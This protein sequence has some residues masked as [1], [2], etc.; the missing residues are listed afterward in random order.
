MRGASMGE[1]SVGGAISE[2]FSLIRR[3]PVTVLVWGAVQAGLAVLVFAVLS[4]VYIAV[5]EAVRAG[6][7]GGAGAQA[8]AT[9]PALAQVQ[10]L[11]YLL[12]LVELG[13][14]VVLYCAAFRAVL[15][16]ERGQFA[17]LRIGMSELYLGALWVGAY[18]ALFIGL[19]AVVVG[20]AIVVGIFAVLHL[21]AVAVGIAVLATLILIA[22]LLYVA[23]RFSLVGPMIVDDGKFHF[24]EAWALTRGHVLRLFL[25]LLVLGL[26]AM[27]GGLVLSIL[28]VAIG[29][30]GLAAVA[31]GFGNLQGFFQQP[32][33]AIIARLSPVLVL[34][35]LIWIPY[36]G[37]MNA[38][39]MAPWARAYRDLK[40]VDVAA[41]FA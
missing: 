4:P 15:H 12:D 34:G 16:P 25:I 1:I 29:V 28:F 39:I 40:P 11:S 23:L 38:I 14:G 7:A 35:V 37:C 20:V 33:G 31:G 26:A 8:L 2:G 21:V 13:V 17:Y 41:A 9:N 27:A 6:A 18:I 36:V 3:A 24:E 32:I 19:L 5:A 30:G 10:G 22:G